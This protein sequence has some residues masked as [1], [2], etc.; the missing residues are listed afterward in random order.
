MMVCDHPNPF[1]HRYRGLGN[2]IFQVA[3]SESEAI[4]TNIWLR[5]H[6]RKSLVVYSSIVASR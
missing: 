5:A 4:H 1:S 2:C 3:P 6:E